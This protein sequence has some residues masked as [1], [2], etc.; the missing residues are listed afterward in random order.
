MIAFFVM[1]IGKTYFQQINV[2]I[3]KKVFAGYHQIHKLQKLKRK[4]VM[5]GLAADSCYMLSWGGRSTAF[6]LIF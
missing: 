3:L 1:E 5:K 6:L 2:L 4:I